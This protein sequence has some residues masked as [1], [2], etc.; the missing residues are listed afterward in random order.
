MAAPALI[1]KDMNLVYK[2][3]RDFITPEVDRV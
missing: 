1:H 2:A 3:A